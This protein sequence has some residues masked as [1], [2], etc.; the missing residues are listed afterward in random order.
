MSGWL[1]LTDEF[2]LN[3]DAQANAQRKARA[4]IAVQRSLKKRGIEL[5]VAVVPDKAALP[6]RDC[7]VSTGLT[8]CRPVSS[9]GLT[10]CRLLASMPWT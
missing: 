8:Y 10:I 3:R 9:A 1:F 7:A 4:V 5:L 2:R 6:Q